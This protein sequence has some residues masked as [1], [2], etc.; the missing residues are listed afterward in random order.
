LGWTEAEF[1]AGYR[2]GPSPATMDEYFIM[3]EKAINNK[4]YIL[5]SEARTMLRTYR[6]THGILSERHHDCVNRLGWS[7]DEYEAG[8]KGEENV[9]IYIYLYAHICIY[10]YAHKFI[11]INIYI[12][13]YI[14]IYLKV[15]QN[16]F[17]IL[18]LKKVLLK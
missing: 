4:E 10:I 15:K 7:L 14:Y 5:T 13:I 9:C 3:L 2:G 12:Y 17:I 18:S 8:F 1:A 11:C 16:E 6:T